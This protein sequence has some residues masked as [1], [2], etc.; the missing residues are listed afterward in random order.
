[1]RVFQ[2]TVWLGI[3]ATTGLLAH[4]IVSAQTAP[5]VDPANSTAIALRL[6][7]NPQ[8]AAAAGFSVSDV[9]TMIGRIEAEEE[10]RTTL[11]SAVSQEAS[12]QATLADLQSQQQAGVIDE[13]LPSQLAAAQAA[14]NAAQA[15]V[16][17]TLDELFDIATDGFASATVDS[18]TAFAASIEYPVPDSYRVVARTDGE[19]K[20]IAS[21]CTARNRAQRL[22]QELA[23]PHAQ[24]LAAVESEPAVQQAASSLTSSLATLEGYFA[25]AISG[26]LSE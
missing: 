18:L 3:V 22:N 7:I 20:A 24:L 17:N 12:A 6:S 19:W 9:Q 23:S 21:A 15:S 10:L 4:L 13:Q 25:T 2:T 16:Q 1:M 11:A 8:S 26:L 5:S 14:L